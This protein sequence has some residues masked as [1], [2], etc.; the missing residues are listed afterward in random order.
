MANGLLVCNPTVRWFTRTSDLLTMACTCA[1]AVVFV[2]LSLVPFARPDLLLSQF[3]VT[4]VMALV[5]SR[6]EESSSHAREQIQIR[7]SSERNAYQILAGGAIRSLYPS[8]S[9]DGRW[10]RDEAQRFTPEVNSTLPL[11]ES[12]QQPVA[13]AISNPGPVTDHRLLRQP[14]PPPL[15]LESSIPAVIRSSVRFIPS[16]N[17]SRLGLLVPKDVRQWESIILRA[18]QKHD[19]DPNLIAA[20]M[21]TESAGNP[22]ALSVMNAVGLMQVMGGSFEPELNIEQG[23]GIF[24]RHLRVYGVVD[25]ALAAYNAGAGAVAK[26]GGIPP[27][28]ETRR[29][30]SLTIA[31]YK[32]FQGS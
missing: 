8:S 30:V 16:T 20:L 25:V 18:G 10:W 13:T 2:A 1:T 9:I 21:H 12:I 26:Y 4:D 23:V 3:D 14:V 27:Y 17:E 29:H 5:G 24:A 15:A 11:I 7:E 32:A 19:V 22:N 28:E 6:F 31:S